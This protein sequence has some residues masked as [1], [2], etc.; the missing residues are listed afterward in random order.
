MEL[1]QA[2]WGLK[3]VHAVVVSDIGIRGMEEY[4]YCCGE[5]MA[6]VKAPKSFALLSALPKSHQVKI[7]I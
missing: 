3:S 4:G 7:L 6:P 2:C 1:R 5:N